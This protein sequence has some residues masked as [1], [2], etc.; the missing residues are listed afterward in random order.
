MLKSIIILV[1]QSYRPC[2]SRDRKRGIKEKEK[3]LLLFRERWV[4]S[5]LKRFPS[6][7]RRQIETNYTLYAIEHKDNK[8]RQCVHELISRVTV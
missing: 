7:I 6:A 5:H 2:K 4:I 8:S 3:H 1:L